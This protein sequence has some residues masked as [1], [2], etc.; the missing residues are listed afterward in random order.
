M[1]SMTNKII[2][3]A[4]YSVGGFIVLVLVAFIAASILGGGNQKD[5]LLEYRIVEQD[6]LSYLNC[7]RIGIHVLVPDEAEQDKVDYTLEQIIS[8]K[9]LSQDAVTV[10]AYGYSEEDMVGQGF[11]KGLKEY[12]SCP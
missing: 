6:D 10:W 1:Q 2:R 7:K 11:T 8:D 3:I 9:K 12:S 5:L 4:K